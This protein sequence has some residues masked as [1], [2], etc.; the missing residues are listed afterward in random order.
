[1]YQRTFLSLSTLTYN[2]ISSITFTKLHKLYQI[3][4]P[5]SKTPG[6]SGISDKEAKRQ[7]ES[8]FYLPLFNFHHRN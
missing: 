5:H 7:A 2:S 1:M 4:M 6:G 3:T 8:T